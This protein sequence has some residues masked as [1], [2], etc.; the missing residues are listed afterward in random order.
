[1][2]IVVQE[3]LRRLAQGRNPYTIYHVPW[4]APLP[5]GPV[6]WGPYAI[7]MA[8]HADIRFVTVAGELFV[9][10]ACAIAAAVAAWRGRLGAAL[11]CLVLVAAMLRNPD[12]ASFASIGHTPSY[13][14]LLALFAWLVVRERWLAASVALGLLIVGR[15]TMVAIVPVLAMTVWKQDPR[16]IVPALALLTL[17]VVLPFLPFAVLDA[18][19]LGY[20]L[21]GSYQNVIKGFVWTSTTWTQHTIG[22]TGVLMAH[23][24]ARFVEPVQIVVMLGVYAAAWRSRGRAPA[25]WMTFALLTFSMTTLW[26]VTYV[27]FDVLLFAAAAVAAELVPASAGVAR[28]LGTWWLSAATATAVLVVSGAASMLPAHT[29]VDVGEP[30]QRPYLRAGFGG[31]EREGDRTFAWVEGREASI[32]LPR[33][34]AGAAVID[35]ICRPALPPGASGQRMSALLNGIFAGDVT[36]PAGWNQVSLAVP[37]QAWRIGVNE[38]VLSL[39]SSTS[40]ADAGLNSDRRQISVSLDRVTVRPSPE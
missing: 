13:W 35:L 4:D 25:A 37:A 29:V 28:S 11:G 6:L 40:P 32:L 23:G 12:L 22:V 38:L 36:L 21:Y 18:R 10:A 33:R 17:A 24:L 7:P 39:S 1:M 8:L 2:L 15:T 20:A 26:P 5:Y 30:A 19:G 27:Y 31:D 3:G 34:T 14:P 9:P 16:R